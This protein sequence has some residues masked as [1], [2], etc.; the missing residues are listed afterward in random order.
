MLAT[1]TLSPHRLT[2]SSY[3]HKRSIADSLAPSLCLPGTNWQR[4]SSSLVVGV[5]LLGNSDAQW[6]DIDRKLTG[7]EL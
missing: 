1:A 6:D 4:E 3:R 2:P 5:S 7:Y